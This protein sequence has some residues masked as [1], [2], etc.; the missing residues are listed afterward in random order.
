MLFKKTALFFLTLSA[1][2]LL[3]HNMVPHVHGHTDATLHGAHSHSHHDHSHEGNNPAEEEGQ[4]AEIFSVFNHPPEGIIF[5]S[6][7]SVCGTTSVQLL[8]PNFLIADNFYLKVFLL[9][10][11][12]HHSTTEFLE[13]LSFHPCTNALRGPP[14]IAV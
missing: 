3:V 1:F 14:S 7:K 2:I 11:L 6:V 8:T 12:L 10:P 5:L 9:P 13:S 4:L